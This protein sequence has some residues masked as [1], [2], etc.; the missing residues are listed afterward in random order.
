MKPVVLAILDGWGIGKKDATNPI[1][2]VN[3]QNINYI[4]RNFLSGSLQSS[5]IAVGLPWN[6]EGNSEVGHLTIG[7]GKTLYQHFPRITLAIQDGSFFKNQVLKKA[8]NFAVK[9]NSAINL[10]GILSEG[11]VHGSFEHLLALIDMA[12][13]YQVPKI[14]LHLF[15]DGKDS[16]LK[17][18]LSLMSRL[19][20]RIGDDKNIK[21][22]SIA[23]RYFAMDRDQH[24]DR[25]Q[26]AY[27][28]LLGKKEPTNNINEYINYQYNR[29]LNDQYLAPIS[30]GPEINP[31]KSNES[32][33]FFNFR[34]DS[35]RQ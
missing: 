30:V 18:F 15:S 21:I 4:K 22:S 29:D 34:E 31:I 35:I 5:G 7:A 28:A 25:T 13:K 12:K 33:I 26:E 14:K 20:Q 19:K 6:E 2:V 23:G 27:N 32:I 3:P 10:I 9:N 1:H 8:C 17:S 16:A 11:N 24:W